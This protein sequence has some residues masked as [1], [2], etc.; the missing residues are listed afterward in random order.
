MSL[1]SPYLG[2][3]FLQ[4]Q[5]AATGKIGSRRGRRDSEKAQRESGGRRSH[6]A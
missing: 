4:H 5:A 6:L 2:E 1:P 3:R